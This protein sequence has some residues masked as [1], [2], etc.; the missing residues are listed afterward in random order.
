MSQYDNIHFSDQVQGNILVVDDNSKNL[1][2]ISMTL[3]K[4]GYNVAVANSGFNALKYLEKKVP[5]L[6]LLDIMMPE[7]DGYEVCKYIKQNTNTLH[8][9][10]IF[11]TAKNDTD[12]LIKGFKIGAVDYLLKP[13]Q[14]E[15]L[16]VRVNTH[17]QLK[18]SKDLIKQHSL[19]N[20]QLSQ[21]LMDSKNRVVRDAQSLLEENEQLQDTIIKLNSIIESKN[22]I[23]KVIAHDL[24]SPFAGLIGL[25]SILKD[26][27]SSYSKDEIVNI[28]SAIYQTSFKTHEL[29][30]ELITW[31]RS[32]SNEIEFKPVSVDLKN[33]ID[34]VFTQFEVS[35]NLKSI[36]IINR[37]PDNFIITADNQLLKI[38]FRS[39]IG[40]SLKFSESGSAITV[41]SVKE[42]DKI[43]VSV[44]DTGMGLHSE[45]AANLFDFDVEN[46]KDAIT[47][48]FLE[49]VGLP[50]VKQFVQM[51]S[52][53]IRAESDLENG[54]K[55]II[56]IP[57]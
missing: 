7:M 21:K 44:S 57:L 39:L 51:H 17:V 16:L 4:A 37:V 27:I 18:K 42:S 41:S 40:N 5:D 52:G 29:L 6:V 1:Q 43:T 24:K 56:E 15:E 45:F 26:E 2:I 46:P 53:I 48:E 49:G 32:Q 28:A 35:S 12:D 13:F 25:S 8:V 14:N 47:G 31:V 10:V 30:V 36:K 50:L 11:L 3:S 19:D 33:L 34:E 55:V 54:L 38:I 9:P 22:K 20:E 23:F